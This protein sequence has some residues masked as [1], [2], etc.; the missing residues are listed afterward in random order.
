MSELHW[1]GAAVLLALAV[2]DSHRARPRHGKVL[3]WAGVVR[4]R[5]LDAQPQ[6]ASDAPLR[7]VGVPVSRG[8]PR[9]A[10]ARRVS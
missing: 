9:P 3:N 2:L 8:L 6:P 4:E 7:L 1:T 10:R 5:D